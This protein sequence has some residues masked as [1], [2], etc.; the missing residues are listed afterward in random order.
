MKVTIITVVLN[1]RECIAGAIESVLCQDYPNIEYIVIDGCSTDGSLEIIK[2][3]EDKISKIIS[4]P[5]RGIYDALNKGILLANGE[6]IGFLHADD[7]FSDSK[8][9]SKIVALFDANT[10]AVYGDLEYVQSTDTN[11]VFRKWRSGLYH[12]KSFLYGWMPPHPTF[13]VRSEMYKKF[14]LFDLQFRSAADYEIMLRFIYKHHIRLKYLP[15]VLVKMRIGGQSNRS[16]KN[17]IKANIEDKSAWAV[18]GLTPRFYTL[19][20]KPLRKIFQFRLFF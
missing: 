5:D 1:N 16:I 15:E 18:N 8:V 3:Y 20:L 11:K 12:K 9:I 7:F 13:Y 19:W 2:R 14:G 4:E 17:R 6:V 10:D